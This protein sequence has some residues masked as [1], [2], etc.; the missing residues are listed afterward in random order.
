M[1]TSQSSGNNPNPFKI[2]LNVVLLIG[3]LCSICLTSIYSQKG[4][5]PQEV[6]WGVNSIILVIWLSN[7][8]IN[9]KQSNE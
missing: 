6:F 4:D 9:G 8:D 2:I 3:F 1:E 7:F 5:V